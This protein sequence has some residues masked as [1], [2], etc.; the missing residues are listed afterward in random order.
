V[1]KKGQLIVFE[2]VDGVGKTTLSEMLTQ[3]LQSLSEDA[4]YFSFPGREPQTLSSHVYN[5]HH[6]PETFDI[7]SLHPASRQIMHI[8][9]H[10][11]A[12]ETRVR[13]AL[14]SGKWVILDRFWWS[15]V[16]YGLAAGV[17]SRAL[18][19][20]VQTEARFWQ[21]TKPA[22][23]F[24]LERG[25]VSEKADA[26]LLSSY[27]ELLTHE[28]TDF[29][30]VRIRNSGSIDDVFKRIQK[31]LNHG[32]LANHAGAPS[33]CAP[34]H[35]TSYPLPTIF[36]RLSP[37]KPTAVYDTYWRFAVE[38]QAIFF[39]RFRGEPA[40]WTQDAILQD[41]K[42][43]NVYRAS[44]RVSQYLIK[45]VIYVGNQS[46]AEIGFRIIL[47][48]LF[49]KIETWELFKSKLGELRA[50]TFAFN[51][52]DSVLSQASAA[53][54]T[55]Y[56]AAYIMPSGGPGHPGSKH[57]MHL[58][59]MEKLLHDRAFHRI[60]DVRTMRKGF[61]LLR[62]YPSFGDF[63][64]YQ[65]ITDINYS[66][67]TDFSEMDFVIPGPG[68]RDGVRKCFSDLGGL[69]ESDII[70]IVAERQAEEFS[71]LGLQFESLWGRPLQLIDCQ[72]LFCE[73]DKYARV[74]HPEIA[75]LSGRTRIKQKF[76]HRPLGRLPY[77][78][79]PKWRIN[80][81]IIGGTNVFDF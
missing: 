49:N 31:Q 72:N 39:R 43:T 75:G 50:D 66:A 13:P 51:L 42:F 2:G 58:R 7:K 46:P 12:I 18:W 73:V 34:I 68:A 57:R 48:K 29:P 38:R 69:S 15:T 9:A 52:Y 33:K 11:E 64:A 30:V 70:R 47:F 20:L 10:V 5:L 1:N 61:E 59:L 4:V 65:Y 22:I 80:D 79:P 17:D 74:K 55:I 36:S 28:S 67:M 24:Y 71:R 32:M 26:N 19:L 77:W 35:E 56:S 76:S 45:N 37:A 23:T 44:D 14:K 78:Y 25:G 16:A 60:A 27:E 8:A 54:K 41:Y 62:A 40:P 6:S 63:L 3:W 21:D 81:N 53:G